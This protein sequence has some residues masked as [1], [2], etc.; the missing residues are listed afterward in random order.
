MIGKCLVENPELF[1]TSVREQ[2]Y[3]LDGH[4]KPNARLSR[5]L[6]LARCAASHEVCTMRPG[7]VLPSPIG[8]ADAVRNGLLLLSYGVRTE[9]TPRECDC[10]PMFRRLFECLECSSLTGMT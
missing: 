5:L 4:E 2:G 9:V 1:P 10:S 8:S 3:W 7:A 6:A